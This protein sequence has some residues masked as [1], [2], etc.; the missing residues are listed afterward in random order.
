M[1]IEN[2]AS[3][4]VKRYTLVITSNEVSSNSK[5]KIKQDEQASSDHITVW[6]AD[7]FEIEGG[8]G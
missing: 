1:D 6:E 7:N 5:G 4:K 2:D 8:A 3:L